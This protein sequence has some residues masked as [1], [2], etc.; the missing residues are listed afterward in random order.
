MFVASRGV[1]PISGL[2]VPDLAAIYWYQKSKIPHDKAA[3]I[4]GLNRRDL[5]KA[6]TREKV[7][8]FAIDFNHLQRKLE[9]E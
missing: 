4:A 9:R 8:I 1:S 7:D 3:Q 5:L 2:P 6:L